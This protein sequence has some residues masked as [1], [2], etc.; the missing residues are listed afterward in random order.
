MNLVNPTPPSRI[1]IAT[2]NWVGPGNDAIPVGAKIRSGN[3][4][5]NEWPAMSVYCH[6]WARIQHVLQIRIDQGSFLDQTIVDL[7]KLT[8]LVDLVFHRQRPGQE[9][10][11]TTPFF[12]TAIVTGFLTKE[13]PA[14]RFSIK[15]VL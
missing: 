7:S 6:F 4:T 9:P 10:Y 14:Y 12:A 5:R 8:S 3:E 1:L 13:V 2:E 15:H 11:P